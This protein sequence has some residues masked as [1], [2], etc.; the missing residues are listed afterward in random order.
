MAPQ[1]YEPDDELN[2]DLARTTDDLIER[3]RRLLADLDAELDRHGRRR[4][5]DARR[6]A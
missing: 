6:S 2:S 5:D 4:R 1:A 3:S